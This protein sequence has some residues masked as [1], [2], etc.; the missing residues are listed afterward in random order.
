M[1]GRVD[2][3]YFLCQNGH[4]VNNDLTCRVSG[5]T[6]R[7]INNRIIGTPKMYTSFIVNYK[8]YV[9]FTGIPLFYT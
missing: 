8:S 2:A 9:A 7:T 4:L 6:Q 1:G 5:R 3:G